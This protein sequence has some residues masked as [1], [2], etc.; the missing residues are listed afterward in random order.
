MF[1]MK[2][3]TEKK[4]ERKDLEMDLTCPGTR[5]VVGPHALAAIGLANERAAGHPEIFGRRWVIH[6][7]P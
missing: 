3:Q 1:L 5:S 2:T 6:D 4:R 7:G